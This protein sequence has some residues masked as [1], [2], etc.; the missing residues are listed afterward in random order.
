MEGLEG[1]CYAWR[2][3]LRT[4]VTLLLWLLSG[5][6]L[7]G[8]TDKLTWSPVPVRGQD[9]L[10]LDFQRSSREDAWRNNGHFKGNLCGLQVWQ[11]ERERER[12]LTWTLK[13]PLGKQPW[14]LILKGLV[15]TR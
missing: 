8:L 13:D 7:Y 6:P 5:G 4:R 14:S 12:D 2:P 1:S 15:I 9:S 11:G 10:A 3:Q